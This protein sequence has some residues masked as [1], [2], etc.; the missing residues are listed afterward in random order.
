[1]GGWNFVFSNVYD[2][3]L[4]LEL[5][6]AVIGNFG[7]KNSKLGGLVDY[8]D[9]IAK[10]KMSSYSIK[11]LKRVDAIYELSDT[12]LSISKRQN[13]WVIENLNG[14]S[15]FSTDGKTIPLFKTRRQAIEYFFQH[16]K[17]S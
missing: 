9:A 2:P 10:E 4:F 7:L 8:L 14:Y 17:L 15:F 16:N 11:P 12:D 5:T 6:G 1:M 3:K 13:K